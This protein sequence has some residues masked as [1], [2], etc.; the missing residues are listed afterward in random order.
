[1]KQPEWRA[2]RNFNGALWK[3][4][5]RC[6][7]HPNRVPVSPRCSLRTFV[8]S[9]TRAA[10]MAQPQRWRRSRP[11]GPAPPGAAQFVAVLAQGSVA[12]DVSSRH[13]LGQRIGRR[14]RWRFITCHFKYYCHRSSRRHTLRNPTNTSATGGGSSKGVPLPGGLSY[15]WGIVDFPGCFVTMTSTMPDGSTFGSSGYGPC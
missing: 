12:V 15:D 10:S 3:N 14:N 13:P 11:A 1:M 5:S 4:D 6:R 9:A 8:S 2:K 7:R